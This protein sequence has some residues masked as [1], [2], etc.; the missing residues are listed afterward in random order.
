MDAIK[1]QITINPV[2]CIK[3]VIE[4][5]NFCLFYENNVLI[6]KY[7]LLTCAVSIKVV[8]KIV[9]QNIILLNPIIIEVKLPK[10]CLNILVPVENIVAVE[11]SC[12]CCCI[13]V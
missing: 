10:I 6:V 1:C 7:L 3:L 2:A 13:V 12:V 5:T 9:K 4:L 8:M 11:I